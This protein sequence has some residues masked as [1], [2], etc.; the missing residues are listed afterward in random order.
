MIF[1]V[2]RT[3][4]RTRLT[5]D[6]AIALSQHGTVAPIM[7]EDRQDFRAAMIDGRTASELDPHSKAATEIASLWSYLAERISNVA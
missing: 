5:A 1:I 4:A 2:N 6:A 3:R 7:I